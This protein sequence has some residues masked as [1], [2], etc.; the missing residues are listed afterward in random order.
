MDDGI[1]TTLLRN[2]EIEEGDLKQRIWSES[3][4]T[5]RVAL[6][7]I[8]ARVSSF[9]T[10]V[11]TQSFIGHVS[12]LDLAGYAL[13][14]TL[15]IRFINGILLGMSSATETLC[16]QSFGA[17]QDHM[18]GI[19]LQRSWIVD[20]ITLTIF[21]PVLIFGTQIFKL[22]GEEESIANSGGY[23]SL[24]FIPQAY[25]YVFSLTIQMY[26]QAQLKNMI[27]AWLS[28]FQFAIH[29]LLSLLFVYKLN[30]GVSGAMLALVMSSWSPVIGEFIYIFGGWCPNSWKGFTFAAFK[31]LMPLV[32]LSVSSGVMLCLELWYNAVLVLLAG[33]MANAEVAISAFS[34]C[35]NISA[36]EFMIIL[37]FLGA[38][39]VRVANELGRGNAKAV[40]FSIKVVLGTST[41]IGVFFFVLCLVFRKSLAYLFTNDER[42]AD[43]ISD[44]SLLLSFSVLLNSVYPVLSGVATGAGMQSTVALVNLVCFYLIGVPLGALLGYLT[45]LEVKGIW[46][47]M[48]GGVLAQTITLIYLIWRTNWDDE[49]KKASERLKRYYVKSDENS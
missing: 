9:G 10:V 36:W 21:L 24:W 48:M 17:G 22:V 5:W 37:G 32:K 11:V 15:S 7:G 33:Y 44:L 23:I 43:T 2:E 41:V 12:D 20:F 45:S 46:I 26:L 40:K 1:E 4:K 6:P 19:H 30:L 18:M 38:A 34:I 35:L 49:V 8:I 47:G 27:V 25:T 14:Q 13:V 3:K 28:V 42:V 29:I 31:D 16:G 39:C